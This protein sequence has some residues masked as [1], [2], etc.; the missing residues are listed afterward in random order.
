MST[1]KSEEYFFLVFLK[2]DDTSG[3]RL[4]NS[5]VNSINSV[6]LNVD[7]IRVQGYDNGSNVKGP[8]R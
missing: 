3:K 4:F 6:G 2:V 1:D 8:I 7:D 5:M